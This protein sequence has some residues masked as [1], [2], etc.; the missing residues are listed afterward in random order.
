M[1]I[2][3]FMAIVPA[4][5]NDGCKSESHGPNGNNRHGRRRQV[6]AV[7]VVIGLY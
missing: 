2:T 7:M 1:V 3:F 5:P 6:A 4:H